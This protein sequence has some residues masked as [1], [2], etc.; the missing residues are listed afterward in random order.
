MDTTHPE[1][2]TRTINDYFAAIDS[3]PGHNP[4]YVASDN[5]ESIQKMIDRYGAY[6]SDDTGPS[7]RVSYVPDMIRA[8]TEDDVHQADIQWN[9]LSNPVFWEE[10][11][12][13]MTA[14][15]STHWI[16][17]RTSNVLNAAILYADKDA[18]VVR[19]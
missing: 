15:A 9:N 10:A 2:G 16:I 3:I 13:D 4:I 17:G 19:I 18:E 11:F 7:G 14:L 8:K 1:Y 5:D 6:N 12:T